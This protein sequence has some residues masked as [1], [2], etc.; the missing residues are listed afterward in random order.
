MINCKRVFLLIDKYLFFFKIN[1]I[2]NSIKEDLSVY[3]QN[4]HT[5]IVYIYIS[6]ELNL[7]AIHLSQ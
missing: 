5:L 1:I 6:T 3:V 7:N 2:N 4:K